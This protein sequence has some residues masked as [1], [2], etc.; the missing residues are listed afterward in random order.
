LVFVPETYHLSRRE[1]KSRYELHENHPADQGYRRFLKRFFDPMNKRLADNSTGLDFG[2]GPGP[3]LHL[4]FEEAGH[5]MEIY[6]LFFADD[7]SVF[8]KKYDF[9]CATEVV[10]HL[11]QP[12]DELNRLWKC[13]K[14][15]GFLGLMTKMVRSKSAFKKWHYIRDE[16]HVSFFSKATFRWLGKQWDTDLEITGG[17][18]IFFQK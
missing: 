17:D 7:R 5:S 9:I 16:T 13:L 12:M 10:E 2:A 1:E 18:L 4:M 8:D 3:T 15:S 11:H 14:P 6:D